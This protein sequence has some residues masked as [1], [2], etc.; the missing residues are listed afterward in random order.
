[1]SVCGFGVHAAMWPMDPS[2]E[3]AAPAIPGGADV[4]AGGSDA[5]DRMLDLDVSARFRSI[6]A[7]LPQMLARSGGDVVVVRGRPARRVGADRHRPGARGAGLRAHRAP[8]GR[9][10]RPTGGRGAPRPVATAASDDRPKAE[11]EALVDGCPMR[12]EEAAQAVTFVLTR[13]SGVTVCDLVIVPSRVD[14]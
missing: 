4:L 1:M 8:A 9:P 12:P 14:L 2:R 6:H 13:P 10:S 3:A 11:A 7:V 5:W